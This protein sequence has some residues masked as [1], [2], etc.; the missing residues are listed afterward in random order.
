MAVSRRKAATA[1]VKVET[2][3][4]VRDHLVREELA[5]EH[6]GVERA[7]ICWYIDSMPPVQQDS[8]LTI[9][10]VVE[11]VLVVERKLL[12]REEV[13]I[14]RVRTTEQHVETVKLREQ[15]PI[16]MRTPL[17]GQN[18]RSST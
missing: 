3:T 7:P 4:Q 9:L 14:W 15:Q 12:L 6:V 10:P 17:S 2:V 8:D 13:R 18:G 5:H 16:V 1:T 11:E